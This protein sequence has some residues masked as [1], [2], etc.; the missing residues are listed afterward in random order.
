MQ[1]NS[2]AKLKCT[3][4]LAEFKFMRL[5]HMTTIEKYITHE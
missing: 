2:V 4:T 3:V 1:F 5:V